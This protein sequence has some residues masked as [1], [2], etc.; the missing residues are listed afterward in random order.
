[1][2]N[3]KGEKRHAD[4]VQNARHYQLL[5]HPSSV[6][7]AG[8][9]KVS[10]TLLRVHH[11]LEQFGFRFVFLEEVMQYYILIFEV[12]NQLAFQFGRERWPAPNSF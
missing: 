1:L 2:R 4:T 3:P 6:H 7:S 11:A 8:D 12:E 9:T 10:K 5:A